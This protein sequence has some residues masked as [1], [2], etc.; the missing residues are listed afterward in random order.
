MQ[1]VDKHDN[2]ASTSDNWRTKVSP[3]P[4]FLQDA[5]KEDLFP[6]DEKD[7]GSPLM[8]G[9]LYTILTATIGVLV[10]YVVS[11]LMRAPQE[12]IAQD[13]KALVSQ[14]DTILATSKAAIGQVS[15]KGD[16]KED[17]KS[18]NKAAPSSPPA[19]VPPAS[20]APAMMAAPTAPA[21]P[22]AASPAPSAAAPAPA[23]A[24]PAAK[25]AAPVQGPVFLK[26]T[27]PYGPP[28]L[29]EQDI[30]NSSTLLRVEYDPSA[31]PPAAP[32]EPNMVNTPTFNQLLEDPASTSEP[33]ATEES[34]YVPNFQ[35]QFGAFNSRLNATQFANRLQEKGYEVNIYEGQS[36]NHGAWYFVRLD[37]M[38]DRTVA[39]ETAE[40]IYATEKLMPMV[41]QPTETEKKI[42]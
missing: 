1:F 10:G 31:A 9:I 27:N 42:R 17:T 22:V 16:A 11:Y 12:S 34:S 41:V 23:A 29:V 3:V 33:I 7:K 37:K 36:R 21:L 8:K 35:V 38:M 5:D 13:L 24:P 32:Y 40:N 28:P 19:A 25:K 15:G 20:S 6:T 18:G 30:F 4:T 26:G 2:A 39:L 14:S